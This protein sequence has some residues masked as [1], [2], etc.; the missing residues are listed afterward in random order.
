[1]SSTGAL[2]L[3]SIPKRM[4]VIGG[5]IIG[6]EMVKRKRSKKKG[7]RREEARERGR[8]R[9]EGRKGRKEEEGNGWYEV[10]SPRNRY[11]M[12]LA[13]PDLK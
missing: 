2:S 10:F 7:R 11:Q 5:G 6:L 13:Q 9:G 4:I 1:M 12:R 8:E 3:K